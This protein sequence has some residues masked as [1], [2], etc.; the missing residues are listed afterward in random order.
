[1]TLHEIADAEYKLPSSENRT[2]G[3]GV[4][5]VIRTFEHHEGT[6]TQT[7][8]VTVYFPLCDWEARDKFAAAIETA[9][10]EKGPT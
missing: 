9:R 3:A 4:I 10:A 7:P 1:M 8:F 6:E 5:G 2:I